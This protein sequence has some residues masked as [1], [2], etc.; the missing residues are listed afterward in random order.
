MRAPNSENSPAPAL[1]LSDLQ[2]QLRQITAR[3]EALRPASDLEAAINGLRADLAEIGRSVTEALP[4]RAVES[5]EIEVKALAQRID[6]SRQSGVDTAA[7]AGLEHGL[8][9]VREALRGLTPAESLV[10]FDETVRALAKK[11]D[12]IVSQ[13]RSGRAAAAG[14][15]DRRLA[16]YRFPCR[17]QRHADEGRGRR[18]SALRQGR[19]TR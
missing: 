11:I 7:L 17:F 15:G 18:A 4:Q 10:G 14:D 16:R 8:A 13:G 12:V 19:R 3:I 5:L 1:D 2:Q 6:H 9:D